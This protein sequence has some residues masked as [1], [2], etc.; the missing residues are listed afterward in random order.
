MV[1]RTNLS[2]NNRKAQVRIYSRHLQFGNLQEN[3][4]FDMAT[5]TA[6]LELESVYIQ[7]HLSRKNGSEV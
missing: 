4:T 2:H 1:G 7:K 3:S 6:Q 5:L